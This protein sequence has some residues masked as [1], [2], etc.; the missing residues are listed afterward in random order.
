MTCKHKWSYQEIDMLVDA[1]SKYGKHWKLIQET[2]FQHIKVTGLRCMYYKIQRLGDTQENINRFDAVELTKTSTQ[3]YFNTYNDQF[4][5]LIPE[6]L[7]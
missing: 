3:S 4:N 7:F 2:I 1:V 6:E 5:S